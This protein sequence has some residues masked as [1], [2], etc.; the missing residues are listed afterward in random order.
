MGDGESEDDI[1]D[2]FNDLQDEDN[3]GKASIM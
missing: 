1:S 3:L 2:P